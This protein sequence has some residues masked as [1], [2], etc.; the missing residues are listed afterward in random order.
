MK[1]KRIGTYTAI[2]GLM[3]GAAGYTGWKLYDMGYHAAP[4]LP[5]GSLEARLESIEKKVDGGGI[6]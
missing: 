3:A 5:Q 4:P 6:F 2:G 1:W